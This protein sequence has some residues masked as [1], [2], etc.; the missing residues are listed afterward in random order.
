MLDFGSQD[1]PARPTGLRMQVLLDATAGGGWNVCMPVAS[2]LGLAVVDFCSLAVA[3]RLADAGGWCAKSMPA[4]H[5]SR[6]YTWQYHLCVR[7]YVLDN[8]AF[9]A[10]SRGYEQM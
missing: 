1:H 6:R 10:V 8:T 9:Q 5:R 2:E 4:P 7:T 3:T